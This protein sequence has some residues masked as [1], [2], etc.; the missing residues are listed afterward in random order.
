MVVEG[1]GQ[2]I[3]NVF[4]VGINGF[5]DLLFSPIFNG[6]NNIFTAFFGNLLI[7]PVLLNF[8]DV[9]N[10]YVIYYLGY[11]CS[12]IPPLTW[13]VIILSLDLFVLI[14]TF[15]LTFG[16]LFKAFRLIKEFVPFA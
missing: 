11:F 6:I 16:L 4:V 3:F 1:L 12:I 14:H 13:D 5:I 7:A 2:L 8:Y 9:L 15:E 10:N